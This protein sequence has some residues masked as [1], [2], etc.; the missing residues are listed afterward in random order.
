M[1]KLMTTQAKRIQAA[2]I[3]ARKDW[4]RY[5]A[6]EEQRIFNLFR[7]SA[8]NIVSQIQVYE[9]AGVVPPA[10][11]NILLTTVVDEMRTIRPKVAAQFQRG[12]SHS[13]DL[14]I[15]ASTERQRP[16]WNK[17]ESSKSGLA[18]PTLA[19]QAWYTDINRQSR[20]TAIRCGH[21]FIET[22]S[23]QLLDS[24]RRD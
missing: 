19:Q 8:Q 3:R 20:N 5:T 6:L 1:A 9:K 22:L 16:Q 23:M 17:A 10:R 11:L 14:G 4:T 13:V 7:Q 12:I 21:R 18:R 2:V 24:N 15:E